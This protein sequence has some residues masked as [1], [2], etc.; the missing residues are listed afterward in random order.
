MKVPYFLSL[1]GLDRSRGRLVSD[2]VSYR[3]WL[4][5]RRQMEA[6]P[7]DV[8]AATDKALDLLALASDMADKGDVDKGWR[9]LHGSQRIALFALKRDHELVAPVKVLRE[10]AD[11]LRPWR[12][13]AIHELLGTSRCPENV[14]DPYIVYAAALIR[15]EHYSNQAYKA[16]LSRDFAAVLV[17]LL[18][19]VLSAIFSMINYGTIEFTN[20]AD[21]N[22]SKMLYSVAVFGLFGAIVSAIVKQLKKPGG[23]FT[24]PE[25]AMAVRVTLLRIVGGA[26]F[27]V[28][29]FIFLRANIVASIFSEGIATILKA[30]NAYTIYAIAFCSG[31]T[32]RFVLRAVSA[33]TGK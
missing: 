30:P 4:E 27:A 3:H 5:A 12:R 26:A 22:L 14:S 20:P 23:S 1:F 6:L 2:I 15:D 24:I 7:G 13:D 11:K 33:V 8:S 31:F 17:V 9:Y 25:T 18:I 32:E 16:R 21:V 10:E 28:I 19:V 29:I